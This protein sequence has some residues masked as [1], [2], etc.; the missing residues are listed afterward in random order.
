MY[1][2]LWLVAVVVLGFGFRWGWRRLVG[3]LRALEERSFAWEE[4][5]RRRARALRASLRSRLG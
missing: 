4:R 3:A 2:V 1:W 5:L